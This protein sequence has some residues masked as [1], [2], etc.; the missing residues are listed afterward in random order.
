MELINH[1]IPF[2]HFYNINKNKYLYYNKYN[3]MA[4]NKSFH[5]YKLDELCQ[6]RFKYNQLILIYNIYLI[7]LKI[8][9]NDII[10]HIFTFNYTPQHNYNV[11]PFYNIKTKHV[12]IKYI[13]Y[14]LVS[15][16]LYTIHHSFHQQVLHILNFIPFT[17]NFNN[18]FNHFF[19]HLGNINQFINHGILFKSH[20]NIYEQCSYYKNEI[21][22][23]IEPTYNNLYNSYILSINY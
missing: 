15:N 13:W 9:P 12:K 14:I 19:N 3:Y 6:I 16:I 18:T 4:Y 1:I 22:I 7:Y 8:L 21:K 23:L 5:K 20:D 10:K 17:H 2:N 11:I